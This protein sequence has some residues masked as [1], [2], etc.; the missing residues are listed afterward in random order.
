V[1]AIRELVENLPRF[2]LD[3]RQAEA[4]VAFLLR[5]RNPR[6]SRPT[7][8]MPPLDLS[9]DELRLITAELGAQ[10]AQAPRP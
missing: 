9:R 7:T 10:G 1:S 4:I 3:E 6:A 8:T 5:S 2:G